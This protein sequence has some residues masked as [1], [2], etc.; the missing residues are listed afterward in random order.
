MPRHSLDGPRVLLDEGGPLA[1]T[2]R[3]ADLARSHADLTFVLGGFPRGAFRQAPHDA[4]D[5][6]LRVAD[7]PLAVW[8]ALV[9]VLA[10][11]EDALLGA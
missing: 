3:F 8:S 10:G 7:E 4:F 1:R 6:V 2:P 9:P 5:H 11:C